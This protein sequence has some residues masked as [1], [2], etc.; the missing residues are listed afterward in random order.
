MRGE[1]SKHPPLVYCL[2]ASL[3]SQSAHGIDSLLHI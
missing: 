2:D 3:L 1:A